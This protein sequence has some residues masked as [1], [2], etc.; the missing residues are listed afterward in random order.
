MAKSNFAE[1]VVSDQASYTSTLSMRLSLRAWKGLTE[2]AISVINLSHCE[3]NAIA[4][5]TFVEEPLNCT[6]RNWQAE[7]EKSDRSWIAASTQNRY[8]YDIVVTVLNNQLLPMRVS[9]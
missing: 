3:S 9:H 7:A 8:D 2:G 4:L 1:I 5:S 6:I